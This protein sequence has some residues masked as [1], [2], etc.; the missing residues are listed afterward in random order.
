M[1]MAELHHAGCRYIFVR[2]DGRGM[3]GRVLQ[4]L[5][6]IVFDGVISFG[7]PVGYC[8]EILLKNSGLS[9]H[10]LQTGNPLFEISNELSISQALPQE[11]NEIANLAADTL[12]QGRFYSDPVIPRDRAE[13]LHREWVR[14]S[15]SG[16]IAETVLVLRQAKQILGFVTIKLDRKT[17][18]ILLDPGIASIDLIAVSQDAQGQGF[19]Q[20]LTYAAALWCVQKNIPYLQV[21][22]QLWN[23]AAIRCYTRV[24]FEYIATA[25]SLRHLKN[26]YTM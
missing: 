17:A 22:T 18:G 16:K 25:L 20:Y 12:T 6:F 5:G 26:P 23:H 2:T 9:A 14:N 8:D 15:L 11:A 13:H 7:L 1:A 21:A 19:G 4:Q 24:G 10:K 3:K